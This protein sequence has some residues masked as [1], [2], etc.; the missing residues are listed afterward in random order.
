[1]TNNAKPKNF[2]GHF[3]TPVSIPCQKVR[4][5]QNISE[6][7]RAERHLKLVINEQGISKSFPMAV[8]DSH[9]DAETGRWTSKDPILFNGGDTNLYGYVLADPINHIDPDGKWA[10]Y[11]PVIT[12]ITGALYR[13]VQNP[14]CASRIESNIKKIMDQMKRFFD[15]PNNPPN[16][17]QPDGP[18]CDP[19]RQSCSPNQQNRCGL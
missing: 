18:I 19:L 5:I 17:E 11:L 7:Q 15:P 8:E 13:C 6:S 4:K 16:P 12:V 10:Q 9:Y 2:F 14:S 3:E 1:V